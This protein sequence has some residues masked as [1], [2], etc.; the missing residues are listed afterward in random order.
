VL[1]KASSTTGAEPS[2]VPGDGA[3]VAAPHGGDAR[4]RQ[5]DSRDFHSVYTAWFADVLRWIRALGAP[6]ADQDDLA[7]EVFVIVHRRLAD[8]DGRSMGGWLSEQLEAPGPTP[9]V[10]LE[11]RE[12]QRMLEA[13]LAELSEPLRATFVLFEA[14]GYTAEEIAEFQR[15]SINTVRARI[16]RARKKLLA[17]VAARKMERP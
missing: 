9:V 14:D 3:V 12:K 4:V 6:S 13:L 16:H 17:L 10:A 2:R 15:S 8:F 7:Q 1:V 11:T 5:F